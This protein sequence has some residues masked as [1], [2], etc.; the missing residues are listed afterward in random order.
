M[1]ES[2]ERS[3]LGC[4]S[5][6]FVGR[7]DA[8][9]PGRGRTQLKTAIWYYIGRWQ[10]KEKS[11][12][13]SPFAPPRAG[14]L[15]DTQVSVT[16]FRSETATACLSEFALKI[17]GNIKK[18]ACPDLGLDRLSCLRLQDHPRRKDQRQGPSRGAGSVLSIAGN[19]VISIDPRPGGNAFVSLSSGKDFYYCALANFWKRMSSCPERVQALR[20]LHSSWV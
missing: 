4:F 10:S 12:D 5:G 19:L 18:R 15:C 13:R 20:I 17:R 14:K 16:D 9:A 1:S 6:Q 3:H 2:W 11:G 7:R 8:C